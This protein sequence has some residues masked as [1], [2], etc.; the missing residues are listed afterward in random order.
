MAC[1]NY[2]SIENIKSKTTNYLG[3]K[4]SSFLGKSNRHHQLHQKA[5]ILYPVDSGNL[6]QPLF[7]TP[8]WYTMGNFMEITCNFYWPLTHL[9]L[10]PYT[11]MLRSWICIRWDCGSDLGTTWIYIH[12]RWNNFQEPW[13]IEKHLN[14]LWMIYTFMFQHS[15]FIFI[16]L[17]RML[18]SKPL[19]PYGPWKGNDLSKW[20]V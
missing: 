19:M 20:A 17:L 14:A 18:S 13:I 10:I 16:T 9:I 11:G 1:L 3:R 8:G 12:D 4:M 5:S 7:S 15:T 2:F 6:M